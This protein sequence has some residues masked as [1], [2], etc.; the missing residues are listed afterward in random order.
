LFKGVL[1]ETEDRAHHLDHF[2]GGDTPE[3]GLSAAAPEQTSRATGVA[4][5]AAVSGNIATP[6]HK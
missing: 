1:V 5:T 2:L 4:P 6:A 3:H